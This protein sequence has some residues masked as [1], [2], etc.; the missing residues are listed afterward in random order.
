[1]LS[2]DNHQQVTKQLVAD[3]IITQEDLNKAKEASKDAVKPLLAH[4]I[5][6]GLVTDEQ[7]T[8]ITADVNNIPYVNLTEANISSEV[9]KLLPKSVAEHY[10]AVPQGEIGRAHV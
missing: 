2:V 10:M 3:G 6:E 5:D 4:L 7:L 1:M 8:K 9:L